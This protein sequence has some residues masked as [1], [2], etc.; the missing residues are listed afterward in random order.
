M[1]GAKTQ[2]KLKN[3][4]FNKKGKQEYYFN[5]QYKN[6]AN[7]TKFTKKLEF[8]SSVGFGQTV[9]FDFNKDGMYGDLIT[10]IILEFN[11][12]DVSSLRTS[13]GSM[14]GYTNA[15]GNALIKKLKFKIGGHTIEEHNS[16]F[17]DIA[18]TM[19]IPNTKTAMYNYMIKR[20]DNQN[21]ANFQGGI[22]Q[23]P[24]LLWFCQIMKE[25][26]NMVLPLIA[27]NNSK[28]ELFIELRSL[29]D[30]LIYDDSSSIS[31]SDLSGLSLGDNN[32]LVDYIL[33]EDEERL[34]YINAK[35]QYYLITQSQYLDASIN[36]GSTAINQSL[37]SFKYP[38]IELF[39]VI[40]K[41]SNKEANN[42]FNYTDNNISDVFKQGF[43]N[44]GKI[45]FNNIDRSEEM[46]GDFFSVAEPFK[47]HDVSDPGLQI[48]MYSFSNDPSN[49]SQPTG[50]CN[51]SNIYDPRLVLT[52]KSGI[53]ESE[54]L[55]YGVNYN[56]L[57]IDEKGRAYLLH[58]LSKSTPE[59]LSVD[60]QHDLDDITKPEPN[61]KPELPTT[62]STYTNTTT[63]PIVTTTTN[64]NLASIAKK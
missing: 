18:S 55:V 24:L 41:N 37:R 30:L 16:E 7:Y 61:T 46:S 59:S 56:I 53:P 63:T 36:S 58:T 23:V 10:N 17:M 2:L 27:L 51:F 32:L 38:I 50:T 1:E 12:P 4:L 48:N 62:T 52:L 13:T 14:I 29:E 9:Y 21:P 11:L 34:R 60:R 6:Y 26:E 49:I 22:V 25:N 35:K 42:Y 19:N 20:F 3:Y 45:L 64:P 31:S 43:I 47:Y 15:V 44:K 54:M 5:H 8:S 57:Q 39:W 28:V 33:L 40:R